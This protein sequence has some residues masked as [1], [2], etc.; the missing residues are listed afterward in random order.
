MPIKLIHGDARKV[1]KELTSYNDLII[2][3]PPADIG[4]PDLQDLLWQVIK[5]TDINSML[6]LYGVTPSS[7]MQVARIAGWKPHS[8]V[9]ISKDKEVVGWVVEAGRGNDIPGLAFDAYRVSEG[10]GLVGHNT[11]KPREWFEKVIP[12][13]EYRSVLDLFAGRGAVADICKE[14][15]IHYTGIELDATHFTKLKERFLPNG[16]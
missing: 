3:D 6:Y 9:E 5:L 11:A 1:V 16:S 7:L 14:R 2:A 8:L 13:R 12:F 10:K 4:Q 15:D